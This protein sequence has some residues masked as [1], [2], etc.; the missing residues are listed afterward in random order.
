M[1]AKPLAGLADGGRLEAGALQQDTGGCI[2]D[3]RIQAAHDTGQSHR[4]LG[5]ADHQVILNKCALLP[6]K[7]CKRLPLSRPAHDDPFS[8]KPVAVKS[9][10][11][12][13]QLHHHQVGDIHDIID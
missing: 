13:A 1:Q 10:Q 12:L 9:M 4:T 7:G 8:C 2:L 11:R 5:I 6:V 3:F